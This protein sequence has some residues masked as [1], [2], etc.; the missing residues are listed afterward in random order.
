M[1]S[2]SQGWSLEGRKNEESQSHGDPV[3]I[4]RETCL[5]YVATIS[6]STVKSFLLYFSWPL[7]FSLFRNSRSLGWS[8]HQLQ[9]WELITSTFIVIL[10]LNIFTSFGHNF[11]CITTCWK[12]C[13]P[14]PSPINSIRVEVFKIILSFNDK[15]FLILYPRININLDTTQKNIS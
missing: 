13:S 1:L 7:I 10:L 8:S 11:V 6:T 12:S 5:L 9:W 14:P 4:K 15:I 2:R 3:L